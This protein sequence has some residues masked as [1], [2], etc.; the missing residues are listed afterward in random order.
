MFDRAKQLRWAKL[1]IGVVITLALI[2]LLVTVFF[3]GGIEHLFAKR[4][5][6]RAQIQDVN[7]LRRGAPVW[8]FGTEV[9]KVKDIDLQPVYGTI[10]TISLRAEALGYLFRDAHAVVMTMGLLGDK[11]VELS[12]GNVKSGP[13][14]PKDV[15]KGG[16]QLELR[17]VME[18]GAG[19]IQKMTDIV[20]KIDHLLSTA[21]QGEGT[22]PKLLHDPSIFNNLEKATRSLSLTMEDLRSSKGTLRSLIDDPSLYQKLL[23]G[24]SSIETLTRSFQEGQ[25]TLKKLIEDPSLYDRAVS[26]IAGL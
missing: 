2:T 8:I 10:V 22:V 14:R 24:A 5:E 20:T 7:G 26:T 17:D 3:A 23:A 19:M 15:I 18:T 6:I 4:I 9:G 25:G 16:S 1:K 11:Y 13:L 21:E 12:T